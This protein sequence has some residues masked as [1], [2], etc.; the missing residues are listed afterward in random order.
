MSAA[1]PAERVA[2]RVREAA[3][4]DVAASDHA[5]F[6]TRAIAF[7]LDAAVIDGAAILVGVVVVL[8]FSVLPESDTVRTAAVAAGGVAFLLWWLAYFVTFWTTTGQ[9]PGNRAMHIRVVRAGGE[10]LRPRHSLIRLA[11][12]VLS[13]PLLWGFVPILFDDRRRGVFDVLAGTVVVRTA[14]DP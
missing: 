10:R 8:I 7:A 1:Q 3:A 13:L 9:T 11:G 5:G 4:A 2:V 6:V 14:R 12:L